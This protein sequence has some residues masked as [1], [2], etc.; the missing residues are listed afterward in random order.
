MKGIKKRTDVFIK[1]SPG[2]NISVDY[3][4]LLKGDDLVFIAEQI[5]ES[6]YNTFDY[7]KKDAI[8]RFIDYV[9]Y[10]VQNGHYDIIDMAFPCKRMYDKEL[11]AK[12]IELLNEHLRSDI[13]VKLLKFFTRNLYA[14]DSNLYIANLIY[15]KDIIQA[16]YDTYNLLKKDIFII[17]AN[18]RTLNVKKIQQLSPFSDNKFSSPL[19]AAARLK[20]ILQFW[21]LKNKIND[22]YT[23]QDIMLSD[24]V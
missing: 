2:N 13:V 18:E 11:E 3:E 5:T 15:S 4:L 10:K 12:I 20:Y 7:F 9:Y 16:L 21:A 24:Q 19:D 17:D 6:S 22:I 23:A 8:D 1:V 14:S